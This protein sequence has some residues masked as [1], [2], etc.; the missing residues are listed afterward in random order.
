MMAGYPPEFDDEFKRAI[1]KRDGYKCA[2]CNQFKRLDV[3]HID[4][5]KRTVKTNC[6]GL[7]RECHFALHRS[8]WLNKVLVKNQLHQLAVQRESG[9]L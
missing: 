4:Y 8:N 6:I 2:L 5:T 9:Y 1:R 7:C 3:H